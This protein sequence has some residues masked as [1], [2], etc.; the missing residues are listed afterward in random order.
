MTIKTR[1][2]VCV[3]KLKPT[4]LLI[5]ISYV[6]GSSTG[7]TGF[8]FPLFEARNSGFKS[9]IEARFGI[10]SMRGRLDAIITL[11][12]T[13]LKDPIGD[14]HVALHSLVFVFYKNVFYKNIEA[15]IFQNLIIIRISP[16]LKRI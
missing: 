5:S 11:G 13:G 7:F 1:K 15:E 10:E 9:K 8:R 14:P 4:R 2:F 12:I 6:A 3:Q 16:R